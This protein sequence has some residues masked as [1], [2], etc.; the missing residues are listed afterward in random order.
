[1]TTVSLEGRL[2]QVIGK[3]FSFKTR[4]L[5]E[6]FS[7]IEANTGKFRSYLQGNGRRRFAV[8]VNGK[9]VCDKNDFNVNVK[10][11]E[12]LIIPLLMGGLVATT[13]A[14][15]AA[16]TTATATAMTIKVVNFVVGTVLMA[17]LSFGISLLIA[18]ILKP[19]D[20]ES[21]NT[22]SFIFGQAENITRQGVVVP[23][24]Y[25]RMQIGSRVIS[26]NIVNSDRSIV[27]NS[28]AN[29]FNSG[30]INTGNSVPTSFSEGGG[31]M[32]GVGV[33]NFFVDDRNLIVEKKID[34]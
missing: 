19:D 5:R 22:S 3:N 1:M 12:V 23:V 28:G 4:N 30:S 14:I 16:I 31:T 7:A 20:P 32:V 24:G 21:L 18:K 8:F 13:A 6:V 2:G 27:D 34:A 26:V 25:G 10:G 11:K 29:S 17:A 9:E 33:G 15:T